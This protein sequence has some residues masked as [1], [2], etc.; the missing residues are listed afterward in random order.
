MCVAVYTMACRAPGRCSRIVRPQ[1]LNRLTE[2]DHTSGGGR[3][4]VHVTDISNASRTCLMDIRSA[5]WSS[6][7]LDM[8]GIPAAA[9]PTIV[10]SAEEYGSVADGPLAGVSLS[11][12][13][14]APVATA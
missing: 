14:S 8:W 10:S 12:V 2:G 9:L 1:L 7:C 6:E 13:Y 3:G 11:G 4:E 5:S